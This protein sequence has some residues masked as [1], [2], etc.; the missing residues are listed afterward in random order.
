MDIGREKCGKGFEAFGFGKLTGIDLAGE[1]GGIVAP[2][3]DWQRVNLAT[4]SFGQGIAVT[5]MQL[6]SAAQAIANDGKRMQPHVV[7]ELIDPR[8][9]SVKKYEPKVLGQP[10]SPKAAAELRDC[11]LGTV[12][13]G[14]G[15]AARVAG[16]KVAGKTGTAQVCEGAKGYIEGRYNSGFMAIVPA[17]KPKIIVAVRLEEPV[18]GLHHGGTSAAPVF[19]EIASRVLPLINVA[20]QPGYKQIETEAQN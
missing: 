17:D 13:Y 15:K 6:A 8:T 9:G 16:Y 5:M 12:S 11:M 1:V 2:Y 19:Q 18:M 20:P 7:K 14:T 4:I 3:K 10:I